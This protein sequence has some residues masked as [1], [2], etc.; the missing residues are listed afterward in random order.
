V[1][2]SIGIAFS[3]NNT[4]MK[5]IEAVTRIENVMASFAQSAARM[6]GSMGGAFSAVEQKM[7][8]VTTQVGMLNTGL[9][10][11]AATARAVQGSLAGMKAP[12]AMG[13]LAG[14]SGAKTGAGTGAGGGGSMFPSGGMV[15]WFM[16]RW[17]AYGA[18][19]HGA[20]AGITDIVLGKARN[21]LV[22]GQNVFAGLNMGREEVLGYENRGYEFI[23]KNPA[24]GTI[25]DYQKTVSEVYNAFATEMDAFKKSNPVE[26]EKQIGDMSEM[27]M[28]MAKALKVTPEAFANIVGKASTAQKMFMD[29]ADRAK[30]DSGEKNIAELYGGTLQKIAT[31]VRTTFMWGKNVGDMMNY[32]LPSAL[33]VGMDISKVLSLGGVL[34]SSG[35]KG[36]KAARGLRHFLEED[37]GKLGVIDM[38]AAPGGLGAYKQ[39]KGLKGESKQWLDAQLTE[40]YKKRFAADPAGTLLK[41]AESAKV[42]EK[43]GIP[44]S[45]MNFPKAWVGQ[46]REMMK[47]GFIEKYNQI[48]AEMP[49]NLNPEETKAYME[50]TMARVQGK[51]VTWMRISNTWDQMMTTWARIAMEGEGAQQIATNIQGAMSKWTSYLKGTGSAVDAVEAG[52]ASVYSMFSY[53]AGKFADIHAAYAELLAK[54][55]ISKGKELGIIP[56]STDVPKIA[57]T[58]QKGKMSSLPEFFGYGLYKMEEQFGRLYDAGSAGLGKWWRNNPLFDDGT[59]A[60]GGPLPGKP[61]VPDSGDAQIAPQSSSTDRPTEVHVFLDGHELRNVQYENNRVAHIQRGGAGGTAYV[62]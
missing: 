56:Q 6:S 9:E 40:L 27:S 18:V 33:D 46:I 60:S 11:V 13:L 29:Q 52:L 2:Q 55:G 16:L 21:K 59:G 17:M 24:A 10:K 44:L 39:Y 4:E 35:Q 31:V 58:H 57:E 62:G 61:Y 53:L 42:M 8:T 30:Y 26:A 49:A 20:K 34:I 19:I 45:M 25:Q 7:G 54:I 37:V 22:E 36:Q 14:V 48:M 28:I 41:A 5:V 12:P 1:E 23:K 47:D 15:P 50:E 38:A 51:D 3:T 32:V 43:R